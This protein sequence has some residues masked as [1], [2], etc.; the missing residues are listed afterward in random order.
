M[1][2]K[3]TIPG[4]KKKHTFV[5]IDF[6]LASINM[7]KKIKKIEIGNLSNISDNRTSTFSVASHS[8]MTGPG[9]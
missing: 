1:Y 7:L 2:K 6:I 4:Q 8:M 9:F 3:F 5:Q